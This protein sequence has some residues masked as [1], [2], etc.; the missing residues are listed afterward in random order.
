MN[1]SQQVKKEICALEVTGTCCITAACYGIA[2]FGRYFD[3]KGLVLHTERAYIAQWAKSLYTQ[4][5]VAGKI[6]AKGREKSRTYEFSVKDPY[7]VEKMLAL[8]GHTGEETAVRLHRENL[9]CSGCFSRFAAAVFLCCGTMVDPR[10]GYNLE[11]VHPRYSV[12]KDFEV[13]LNEN[14]FRPR[15]TQRKGSNV[16]Y[17]K[18]SEQ[19]EDLLTTMGASRSTLDIM[20]LKVY[21]DLRNKANRIT[22]CETANIDKIVAANK[23]VLHAIEILERFGAVDALPV[24]LRNAIELR[25]TNPSMSLAELADISE[26]PVSKSGLSHR[27]RKICQKAAELNASSQ[28]ITNSEKT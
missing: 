10:K 26:E 5:G 11:F 12:M 6:F 22:N 25:R 16:L 3:T 19:I 17:F 14:D 28:N 13:L 9:L 23:E 18:S 21:K 1:F 20:N 27:Y 4:M 24:A 2:C 8:F 15:H 7:E